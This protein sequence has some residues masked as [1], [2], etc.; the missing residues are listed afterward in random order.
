[1]DIYVTVAEELAEAAASAIAAF[2][3]RRAKS[4]PTGGGNDR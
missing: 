2:I 3:L 4:V 1:M